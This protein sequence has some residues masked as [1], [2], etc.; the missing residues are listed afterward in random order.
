MSIQARKLKGL[1]VVAALTVISASYVYADLKEE[2]VSLVVDKLVSVYESRQ[3]DMVLELLSENI[4][5][6]S[7]LE[8]SLRDEYDRYHSIEVMAIYGPILIRG[9][10]ASVKL[11]W[12]KK[13]IEKKTG[14]YERTEG[15]V[16]LYFRL[17]SGDYKLIRQ[18]GKGCLPE[19]FLN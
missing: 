8:K 13:R 16:T 11:K 1:A 14:S 3:A 12:Y 2:R 4:S 6:P 7:G 17:E 5:N 18:E 19:P 15:E 9:D 10:T